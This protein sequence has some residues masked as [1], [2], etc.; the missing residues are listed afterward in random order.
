MRLAARHSGAPLGFNLT[1]MIDIVFLLI[2][3][4]MA[5][6]QFNR[7]LDAQL[8][9]AEIQRGGETVESSFILSIDNRQRILIGGKVVTLD[10]M[11]NIVTSDLA[12]TGKPAKQW[13]VRVRCDRNQDSER[14]NQVLERLSALGI[15]EIQLSV[16]R[17]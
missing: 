7:T 17:R 6:S 12:R 5:V 8:E 10:Q 4:F 1:S 9:L 11:T 3:F 15:S 14:L 2:I 13:V 16:N